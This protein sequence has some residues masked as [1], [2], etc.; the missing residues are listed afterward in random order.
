MSKT[1]KRFQPWVF[2]AAYLNAPLILL[3]MAFRVERQQHGEHASG[4]LPTLRWVVIAASVALLVHPYLFES[5]LLSAL[6]EKPPPLGIDPGHV[7]FLFGLSCSLI[8]AM[9]GYVLV[10]LGRPASD[11][12]GFVAASLAA[13]VVWST[14]AAISRRTQ[15]SQ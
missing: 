8:P 9:L 7:V 2:V 15:A 11:M 13:I 6:R 14:R 5:R 12:Y 1:A 4:W 3:F 10:C